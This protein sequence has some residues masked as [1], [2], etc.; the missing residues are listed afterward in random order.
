MDSQRAGWPP[1]PGCQADLCPSFMFAFDPNPSA[2]N[3]ESTHFGIY[4]T[5]KNLNDHISSTPVGKLLVESTW[6]PTRHPTV[7]A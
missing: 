1:V 3:E 4:P 7:D 6:F 2:Y 5:Q